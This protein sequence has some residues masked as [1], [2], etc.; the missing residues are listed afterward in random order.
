MQL[1]ERSH[2][3][4]PPHHSDEDASHAAQERAGRDV[5]GA[6]VR[7]RHA[8]PVLGGVHWRPSRERS[9]R[10]GALGQERARGEGRVDDRSHEDC[11]A[12]S[13]K[14]HVSWMARSWAGGDPSCE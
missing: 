14:A 6:R 2:A 5:V 8:I 13:E 1:G 12:M 10:H 9:N 7:P 11:S 3:P 4:H